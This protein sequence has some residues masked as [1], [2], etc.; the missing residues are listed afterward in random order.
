M[1][2]FLFILIFFTGCTSLDLK[3]ETPPKA[4]QAIHTTEFENDRKFKNISIRKMQ[5]DTGFLLP[6]S[7]E[8]FVG[9]IDQH[10]INTSMCPN[11][12]Y[13]EKSKEYFS[14]KN[15]KHCNEVLLR[16]YYPTLD[17]KTSA[18][19]LI[20]TLIDDM[21]EFTSSKNI[22]QSAQLKK[23]KSHSSRHAEI[24]PGKFPVIFFVP[25]YGFPAQEYKILLST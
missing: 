1:L 5:P 23:M 19:Y 11:P 14:Q 7:G 2:R 6:P 25:G 17:Q 9:Y 21:K 3:N 10:I 13:R 4:E 15:Q 16:I 18:Y 20:P 24:A 22:E 12:Y 8:F